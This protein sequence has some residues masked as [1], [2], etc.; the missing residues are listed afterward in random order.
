MKNKGQMT[1]IGLLMTLVALVVFSLVFMPIYQD[2]VANHTAGWNTSETTLF[3]SLGLIVLV[4]ILIGIL[5]YAS[6]V[7]ER[8][9]Q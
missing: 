9:F 6:S 3:S 5:W 1:I 8:V 7:R 2:L 4:A